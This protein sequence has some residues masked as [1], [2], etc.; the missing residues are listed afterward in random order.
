MSNSTLI[1]ACNMMLPIYR[2]DIIKI[3]SSL[4]RDMLSGQ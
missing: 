4:D 3:F 1:H 2:L